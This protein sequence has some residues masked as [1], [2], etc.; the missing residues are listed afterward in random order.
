MSKLADAQDAPG[1]GTDQSAASKPPAGEPLGSLQ[2][3]S[4]QAGDPLFTGDGGSLDYR[5]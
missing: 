3:L 1:G 4:E 5:G 2:K